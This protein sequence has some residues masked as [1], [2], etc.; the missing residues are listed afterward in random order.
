MS[1][2]NGGWRGPNIIKEGLVLYLDA[3]SP[4]SFPLVNQ[5][6]I[7]KDISGN[8]YTGTLTNDPTFTPAN[9]GSI[10]FDGTNDYV[11]TTYNTALT[12]F[13]ACAWFNSTNV[14]GYQRVLDK[15][16]STGFWIGRN[17]T[18]ANSWGGGVCEGGPP[19]GRFITLT[20]NQ[21]HYIVSKRQGTTHTILGDGITNTTSGTVTANALSTN[22][23][24]LGREYDIGPS[25]FKGN[26]SIVHIYN[27]ALSDQEILQNFNA[28]RA[29][30]GV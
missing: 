24:A 13:T 25:I 14:S 19:Y 5:S 20:D 18:L 17:T 22:I 1:T 12:D 27:R 11:S 29:R 26:I 15:S 3:S 4:T 30:F 10:V 9:G 8:G 2:V 28:T 6:T 23:L 16:F 7:W 21:W